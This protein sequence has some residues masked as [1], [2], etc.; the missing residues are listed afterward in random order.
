MQCFFSANLEQIIF[1]ARTQVECS[2]DSPN[3]YFRGWFHP[4]RRT[5]VKV[6]STL[7]T[8]FSLS[9]Y[10]CVHTNLISVQRNLTVNILLLFYCTAAFTAILI[11]L[12]TYYVLFQRVYHTDVISR[13]KLW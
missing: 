5:A 3:P 8:E 7:G 13:A 4:R 1:S 6:V 9:A 12:C 10:L 2:V 11:V